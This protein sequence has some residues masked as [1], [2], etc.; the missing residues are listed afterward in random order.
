MVISGSLSDRIGF[1]WTFAL[2][3]GLNLLVIP[4]LPL[5]FSRKTVK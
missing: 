5:I 2:L 1:R 4:L 3:G